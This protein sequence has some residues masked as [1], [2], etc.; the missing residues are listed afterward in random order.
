MRKE[1]KD[2]VVNLLQKNTDGLTVIEISRILKISRNTAALALEELKRE[3]LIRI[4]AIGMARL[5]YWSADA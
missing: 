1:K 5:N 3:G 2:L 4:R